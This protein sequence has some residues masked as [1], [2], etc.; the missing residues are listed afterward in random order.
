MYH[1][2]CLSVLNGGVIQSRQAEKN[3]SLLGLLLVFNLERY[4]NQHDL[5][6]L[7]MLV[8]LPEPP[9]VC[10]DWLVPC[11]ASAEGQ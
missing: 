1:S 8:Q 5:H 3:I 2:L 4:H 7:V 6:P 11:L 10:F 9:E